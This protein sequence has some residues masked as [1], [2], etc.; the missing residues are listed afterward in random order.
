[1]SLAREEILKPRGLQVEEVQVP[2]MGGSVFVRV[3]S[4]IERD[5][6]EAEVLADPATR[7]VNIR[8]RLAVRTICDAQ[9]TLIFTPEDAVEL[10]KQ[11][12][13]GLD[14]IVTASQRI[15]R[16]NDAALEELKG[17]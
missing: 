8:A 2:E 12:W 6:F 9:G 16:L 5:A 7:M 1:M 4:G 13:V 3:M 17:N 14:R 11:A 15:N 10:G